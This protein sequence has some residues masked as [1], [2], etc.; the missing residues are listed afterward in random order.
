MQTTMTKSFFYLLICTFTF[1]SCADTTTT[2]TSLNN[3]GVPLDMA[4]YRKKQ[5]QDVVYKLSLSIPEKK[6]TAIAAKLTLEATITD[7]SHP[8]YLDFKEDSS[9]LKNVVVNTKVIA[10]THQKEHLI[11]PKEV[12]KLGANTISIEFTAGELSLNRNTDYLYTLLVPDRARTF[13][14]CFD[15]PNIK[16]NYILSISAPKDWQVLCAA[17]IVTKETHDNEITY[18]FGKSDKM[19]TYLFSFVAGKFSTADAKNTSRAMHMLYR[20]TNEEKIEASIA[21]IFKLHQSSLDFLEEYTQYDFPFQKLDF[22]VIPGF[23]YGGMEH[24]GA[25][26]YR[27][28]SLF[29]DNSATRTR[30][31]SR[32][33]L[34][35]HE[36]AHMWFGNLVTMQWFNDVW[37]KEVFANFMADKIV[38]PV[39]EDIDHDLQFLTSHYPSAYGVDR[40]RGTNPIRQELDNLK[41]AGSLYGSI[42][43]NKAPIMMRQL[44]LTLG[45]KAF[46]EGIRTY[47]KKYAN[48]NADWNGLVSI[49]DEKTTIDLKKWS[50]VWVNSTGRPVF[51]GAIDYDNKG[52]ISKFTVEQQAEDGSDKIWPQSFDI[53]LVYA[54]TTKTVNI[55]SNAKSISVSD[56]IGLAKPQYILYNSNGYGYGVFPTD[57]SIVAKTP[58]ITAKVARAQT[59]LNNYEQVLNG[60]LS[61]TAVLESLK[62]GVA[63]ET[64]ELLLSLISRQISSLYWNH[65]TLTERQ[66]QQIALERITYKRLQL[67]NAKN[68]QKILFNVYKSIAHSATGTA[69]LYAIWTKE[70]HI[71]NLILNKNNYTSLAQLLA[72]YQHAKAEDILDT[73]K[74]T[75]SNPDKIER[76]TFLRPALSNDPAI[77]T[78]FFESFRKAENREK[79]S[80]VQT[81]CSYINHPLRQGEGI[82]NIGLSL[83]LLEEIQKTGDIFFPKRWLDNTI[84][85]YTSKEAYTIVQNYMKSHPDLDKNLKRKLLQTT[86]KLYRMHGNIK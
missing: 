38:N 13:F 47:I 69:Y 1:L 23:Q 4:T 80:W 33:K 24:T 11:I 76:F 55:N 78:A 27:E 64:N 61:V 75:L 85:R 25:I 44:E 74:S 16:A 63:T 18:Q 17:P 72:L 65:L 84:G 50:D 28:A 20:E 46:K 66:Q 29:L 8:L 41:N 10:I 2:K 43:Y 51:N 22:A 67:P 15:Q 32:A 52:K 42:I 68:I 77:R 56:A 70:A 81:A 49:L 60:N 83:E 86:D 59:Y 30:E 14:P 7:L 82:K 54:N 57:D 12:L 71:E 39:F 48:D 5:V 36:T 58:I 26:Q 9:A 31:L 3:T 6:E 79:E 53:S 73:A 34:I 37:M 62:K 35:A 45:K 40:T 21:P 19:S